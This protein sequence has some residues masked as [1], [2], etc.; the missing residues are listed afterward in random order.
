MNPRSSNSTT[1]KGLFTMRPEYEK[2]AKPLG[3]NLF[4]CDICDKP[5]A[6]DEPVVV[7]A[8]CGA[9]ICLNCIRSGL[10][11]KHNCEDEEDF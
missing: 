8:D 3:C 5:I 7:C 9:V 11:E 10:A 1:E 6:P 4:C 2:Y